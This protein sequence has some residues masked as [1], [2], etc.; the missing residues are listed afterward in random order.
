MGRIIHVIFMMFRVQ[1]TEYKIFT[2]VITVDITLLFTI[3]H[4][5]KTYNI[6]L[7][8]MKYL[9]NHT[10]NWDLQYHIKCYEVLD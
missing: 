1:S 8:T 2:I 3:R 9:T 4:I 5:T 10:Y 6:I 7:N